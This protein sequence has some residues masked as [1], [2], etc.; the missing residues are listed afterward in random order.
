[1][2]HIFQLVDV[3]RLDGRCGCNFPL[4][5]GS[6]PATCDF[7]SSDPCCSEYGY[8]GNT[9]EHCNY[10]GIDYRKGENMTFKEYMHC[11]R[12]LTVY[13]STLTT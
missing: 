13:K 7:E 4:P 10:P 12:V 8:C 1:M 3:W 11:N 2:R 5:D 6:G 9:D